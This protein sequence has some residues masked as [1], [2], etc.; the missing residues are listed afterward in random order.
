MISKNIREGSKS[1]KRNNIQSIL[2]VLA[3]FLLC[4]RPLIVVNMLCKDTLDPEDGSVL[5]SIADLAASS[6]LQV[7]FVGE[8]RN[9]TN[10][11]CE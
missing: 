9:R 1:K 11:Q 6:K 8:F 5:R 4:S 3:A 10:V 2:F 7:V